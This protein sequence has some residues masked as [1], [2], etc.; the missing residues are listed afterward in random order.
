MNLANANLIDDELTEWS[1]IQQLTFVKWGQRY[2]YMNFD[3]DNFLGEL[4]KTMNENALNDAI[5]VVENEPH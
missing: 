4:N 5:D 2:K 1:F 3:H